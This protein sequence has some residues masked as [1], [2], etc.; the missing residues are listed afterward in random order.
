MGHGASRESVVG[1]WSFGGEGIPQ[2]LKPG[3]LGV[4]SELSSDPLRRRGTQE[5]VG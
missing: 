2:G 1:S 5:V 3:C 4:M